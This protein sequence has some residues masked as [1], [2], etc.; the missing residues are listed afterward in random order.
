L[1]WQLVEAAAWQRLSG[2]LAEREFLAEAWRAN[3]FDI[4]SYWARIEKYSSLRMVDAYRPWLE[5]VGDDFR[6]LSDVYLL[7]D[8]AGYRPQAKAFHELLSEA[9]G[10]SG[11]RTGLRIPGLQADA[12]AARGK[13]DDAMRLYK[14]QE[15]LCRENGNQRTLQAMLAAQAAILAGRDLYDEAMP[16]LSEQEQICCALGERSGLVGSLGLQACILKI[17]GE[18]DGAIRLAEELERI[19]RQSD[20]K[21]TLQASLSTKADILRA[22]GDLN[23]AIG[24]YKEQERICRE[25]GYNKSL[26]NCLRHQ[27]EI[28]RDRVDSRAARH[29][30]A[31]QERIDG[32]LNDDNLGRSDVLTQRANQLY[33][34]GRLDEAMLLDQQSEDLS[35]ET[36]NR[37][38]LA[39]SFGNQANVALAQGNSSE[40]LRLYREA[41]RIYR[42]LGSKD[43]LQISL[44]NQAA[45]LQ[46]LQ[47]LDEAME[48]CKEQERL[49]RELG[50]NT[51]LQ[52]VSAIRQWFCGLRGSST[53]RNG[54]SKSKNSSVASWVT[55]KAWHIPSSIRGCCW[56]MSGAS[57]GKD[58]LWRKKPTS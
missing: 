2:L 41:E 32:A 56:P 45:A 37:R 29:L 40:A 48:V 21:Q 25:F 5:Q 55:M 28:L 47:R 7:H 4:S 24:A 26:A 50:D 12:M 49:C 42:E 43:G 11:E 17:R 27:A 10:V 52:Q 31:E 9:I 6:A 34:Q 53:R 35:R 57:P 14:E 1:P 51:S 8:H 44:G 30:E 18:F 13:M 19:C 54:Y 38:G 33:S 23:G 46:A 20:D 58:L 16:L 39:R 3:Q 22:K 36:G 15:L